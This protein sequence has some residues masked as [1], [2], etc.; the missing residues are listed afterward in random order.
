VDR[1]FSPLPLC[2][3]PHSNVSFP[4]T[5]L[6]AF[7]PFLPFAHPS[8]ILSPLPLCD[9]VYVFLSSLFLSRSGWAARV[10]ARAALRSFVPRVEAG[11]VHLMQ[12]P[13]FWAFFS[14]TIFL[15]IFKVVTFHALEFDC[16]ESHSLPLEPLLT[17]KIYDSLQDSCFESGGLC[18]AAFPSS[19]PSP[20]F[21]AG[22]PASC[23]VNLLSPTGLLSARPS[24]PLLVD[25]A[26]ELRPFFSFPLG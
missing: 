25:C 11:P 4:C 6:S 13:G 10:P 18:L 17:S 26:E 9:H 3:P 15:V 2:P 22:P 7:G 21:P 14:H 8:P 20:G 24:N 16:L 23:P 1:F 12:D 19:T 5:G